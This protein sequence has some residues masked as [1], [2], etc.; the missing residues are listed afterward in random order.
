[1]WY[2][3]FNYGLIYHS[4]TIGDLTHT[5]YHTR[6]HLELHENVEKPFEAFSHCA[7][8]PCIHDALYLCLSIVIKTYYPC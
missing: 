6:Q 7:Q 2:V 8:V 3:F 5:C 1:M 4:K